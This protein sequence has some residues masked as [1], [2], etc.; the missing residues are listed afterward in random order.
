MPFCIPVPSAR[1]LYFPI[2]NARLYLSTYCPM[3]FCI[4]RAQPS[5]FLH[6]KAQCLSLKA[7]TLAIAVCLAIEPFEV[8]PVYL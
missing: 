4:S 7:R 3:P 6:R 5:A 8:I 1:L 2:P